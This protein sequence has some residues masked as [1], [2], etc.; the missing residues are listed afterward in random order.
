[1]RNLI[2]SSCLLVLACVLLAC[3]YKPTVRSNEG[4]LEPKSESVEEVLPSEQAVDFEGVSFTYDPRVFGDVKKEVVPEVRLKEPDEIPDYVAPRHVRFE[5]EL[6]HE[7][8]NARIEV[9][10][11]DEFPGVCSVSRELAEGMKE[12]IEGLRKVLKDPSYRRDGQIPH[13]PFRQASDTFYV[14]VRKFDFQNGNGIL[15]ITH[16]MHGVEL[17]SNRS[18]IYRFE[19]ITADGKYYVTAETPISVD[20][21]PDTSPEEFE[22]YTYKNALDRWTTGVAKHEKYVKSITT[23]LEKLSS[24]DYS[25]NLEKFEAIISSVRIDSVKTLG[26]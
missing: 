1:M 15:F 12:E 13:L 19:G 2:A 21:L 18:L 14:N 7:S 6:G 16:W 11:L 25:P 4:S 9:Y 26:N 20:F 23:R 5:F 24:K 8:G 22:G 10:P 3:S 17:V